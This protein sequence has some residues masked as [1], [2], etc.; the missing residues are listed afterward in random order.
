V[1]TGATNQLQGK[2]LLKVSGIGAKRARLAAESLL[3]E[4]ATALLSW[5][6]AG[7]LA[8]DLLPGNL[9]LPK[10]I[11]SSDQS[12]FPVDAGWHERLCHLLWGQIEL[13]PDPLAES[14][15]ILNT[16]AEKRKLFKQSGAAA[17]D[18]ES[19]AVAEVASTTNLPL[20]A[21]RAIVDPFDM[22][23]P[24]VVQTIDAYGRVRPLPLLGRLARN[25]AELFLLIR[26]GR[27]FR[28][29]RTSLALVARLARD[30]RFAL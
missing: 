15:A 12:V 10:N 18:M 8:E 11:I 5:G 25:P 6:S 23:M 7:G 9:I 2:I 14:T 3:A 27:Y 1:V 28:A 13:H 4:G 22:K 19:A 16:P 30:S 26:L 21:V 29:A 17:V 20:I 24:R